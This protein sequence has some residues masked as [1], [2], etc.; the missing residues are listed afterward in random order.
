[1]KQ[2]ELH[3]D[4]IKLLEAM[5]YFQMR[6]KSE[7]ARA[8]TYQNVFPKIAEKARHEMDIAQ[9]AKGRLDAR[10]AK[11]LKELRIEP[12]TCID[13]YTMLGTVFFINL[14]LFQNEEN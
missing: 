12:N 1:M 9:R 8:E 10:Y 4:C 5:E 13:I 3:Q 14:K 11:T 7:S 6:I 2:I